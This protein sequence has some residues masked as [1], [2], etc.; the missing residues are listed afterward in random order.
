MVTKKEKPKS[1]APK[2]PPHRIVKEGSWKFCKMCGS[3][4]KTKYFGLKTLGC[5]QSLCDNYY[6]KHTQL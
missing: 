3:S 2:F 4:L 5:I 6:Q 1:M